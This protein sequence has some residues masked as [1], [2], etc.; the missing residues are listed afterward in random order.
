M[1]GEIGTGTTYGR[2]IQFIRNFF[3][4]KQN[5]EIDQDKNLSRTATH[6]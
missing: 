5:E 6:Q 4:E 1:A 2:N 3:W